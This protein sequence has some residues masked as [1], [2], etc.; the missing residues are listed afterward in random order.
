MPNEEQGSVDLSL[1]DSKG[2]R[3]GE[4]GLTTEGNGLLSDVFEDGSLKRGT[5]T[6]SGQL[7]EGGE[8][9]DATQK[10]KRTSMKL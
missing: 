1:L 8:A 10:E 6:W 9:T 5:E 4:E 3:R 7:N 2:F